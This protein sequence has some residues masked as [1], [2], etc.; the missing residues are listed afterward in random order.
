MVRPDIL[1]QMPPRPPTSFALTENGRAEPAR[2][3]RVRFG[4]RSAL[5]VCGSAETAL[6]RRPPG[7]RAPR[8]PGEARDGPQHFAVFRAVGRRPPGQVESRSQQ[9]LD[10]LQALH[11][12]AGVV[13]GSGAAW[14]CYHYFSPHGGYSSMVR[15]PVCGTGGCGFNPRYPPHSPHL[16]SVPRH[17]QAVPDWRSCAIPRLISARFGA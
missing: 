16:N 14:P 6:D 8:T 2:S 12:A 5:G 15:A 9:P 4:S 3:G 7:A 10:E 1:K 17:R 11:R 13:P